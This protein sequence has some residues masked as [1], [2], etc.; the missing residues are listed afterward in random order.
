MIRFYWPGKRV[1]AWLM[2]ISFSGKGRGEPS[3]MHAGYGIVVRVN[4]HFVVWLVSGMFLS[5]DG[6][7]RALSM[8]AQGRG[9]RTWSSLRAFI[10]D[11]RMLLQRDDAGCC[12]HNCNQGRD[13]PNRKR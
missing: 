7:G 6:R 2:K 4:G 13:C 10:A 3:V 5:I 12:N 9:V 11:C 1:P 8:E